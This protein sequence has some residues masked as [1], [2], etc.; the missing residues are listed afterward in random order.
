MAKRKRRDHEAE[1]IAGLKVFIPYRRPREF[2][3][4][5]S[6]VHVWRLVKAGQFPAPVAISANRR[7]WR[8]SDLRAWQTSRT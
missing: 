7:A 5:W 8:E 3:A 1:R 6:K 4:P 2:G